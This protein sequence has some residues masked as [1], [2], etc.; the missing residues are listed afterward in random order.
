MFEMI[1]CKVLKAIYNKNRPTYFDEILVH[2]AI[3]GGKAPEL[4]S[5]TLLESKPDEFLCDV[6]VSFWGT[7]DVTVTS[8]I[9]IKK[10]LKI[11]LKVIAHIKSFNGKCRIYFSQNEQKGWYSFVNTPIINFDLDPILGNKNQI[12]LKMFPKIKKIIE[13]KWQLRMNKYTL[14]CKR[15]LTI[16]FLQKGGGFPF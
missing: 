6:D 1:I 15:P 2:R 14:P 8:T 7:V 12:Y 11:P 16:P 3:L 13:D 4:L 5:F 9:L 10:F